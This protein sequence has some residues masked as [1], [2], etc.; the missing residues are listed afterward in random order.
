VQE[1]TELLSAKVRELDLSMN[2]LRQMQQSLLLQNRALSA[3]GNAIVITDAIAE[4]NPIIYNNPAFE[5]LTGYTADQLRGRNCRM[6][7]G[8]IPIRP[9]LRRCARQFAAVK[10]ASGDQN[11]PT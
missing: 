9:P 4:D 8:S 7:Q 3:A 10:G 5:R 2:S 6:L 1:R 11:L